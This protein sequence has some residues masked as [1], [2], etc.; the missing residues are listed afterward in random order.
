MLIS[1]IEAKNFKKLATPGTPSARYSAVYLNGKIYKFG[2][3][4]NNGA[5]LTSNCEVYDIASNTWSPIASL[6]SGVGLS[7]QSICVYNNKIYLCGGLKDL[8]GSNLSTGQN[9]IS[10]D[11]DTNTYTTLIGCPMASHQAIYGI[12]N[13]NKFYIIGGYSTLA[14]S[15]SAINNKFCFYDFATNTW[16]ATTSMVNGD[17]GSPSG[18]TAFVNNAC[19]VYNNRIYIFGVNS[20][21]CYSFNT[22]F[23]Y[24]G[25]ARTIGSSFTSQFSAP[26]EYGSAATIGDF[27]YLHFGSS[28]DTVRFDPASATFANINKVQLNRRR[29]HMVSDGTRFYVLSGV[30]MTNTADISACEAYT[31]DTMLRLNPLTSTLAGVNS[32]FSSGTLINW[33]T[34]QNTTNKWIVGSSGLTGT[35]GSS[36]FISNA[37]GLRNYNLSTE[38]FSHLYRDFTVPSGSN[39]VSLKFFYR[40]DGEATGSTLWD[41]LSVRIAP[42]SSATTPVA[43]LEWLSSNTEVFKCSFGQGVAKINVTQF[44][45]QSIRVCFSWRNDFGQGTSTNGGATIDEV[46]FETGNY[47]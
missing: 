21:F 17:S 16:S 22:T 19:A 15:S 4:I 14:S 39:S 46:Y 38:A 9:F 8:T 1:K 26:C 37:V 25:R 41:Y 3:V 12:L 6:P 24:E 33:T 32:D 11:P 5:A 20:N 7:A 27:I 31:P 45:G 13:T 34:A 47:S 36:A 44:A 2:G 10:Y 40:V 30:N 23:R 18:N 35:T 28:G 43:D 29:Y 42:T